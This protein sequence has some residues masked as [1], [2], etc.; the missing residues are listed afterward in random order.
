M[1]EELRELKWFDFSDRKMHSCKINSGEEDLDFVEI[2]DNLASIQKQNE[3][4]C[5]Q[6]YSLG[7]ALTGSNPGA[8]GFLEGWILRS[9]KD[10]SEKE[11]GKWNIL[12]STETLSSAELK[13]TFVQGLREAADRLEKDEDFDPSNA[14]VV[15]NRDDGTS[16][17]N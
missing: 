5:K 1:S 3:E 15:K 9:L 17:F 7:V 4:M 6:I 2:L 11:H 10:K 16:L 14:P 12:H 13:Q 8:R